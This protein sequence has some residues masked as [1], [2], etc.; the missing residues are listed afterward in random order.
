MV[1]TYNK[2]ESGSRSIESSLWFPSRLDINYARLARCFYKELWVARRMVGYFT[3][4]LLYDEELKEVYA[5]GIDCFYNA[6]IVSL[7]AASFCSRT[8]YDKDSNTLVN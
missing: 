5:L 3:I 6:K 8:H 2:L 7:V 4:D 1:G